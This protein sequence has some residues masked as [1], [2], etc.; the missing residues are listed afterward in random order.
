M[1]DSPSPSLPPTVLSD[2]FWESIAFF[3]QAKENLTKRSGQAR[4]ILE[5]ARPHYSSPHS[6]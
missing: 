6:Q 3:S 4:I 2:L 5:G 1:C